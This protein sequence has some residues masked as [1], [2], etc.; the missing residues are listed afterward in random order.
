[1]A[2]S[3]ESVHEEKSVTERELKWGMKVFAQ[4][5]SVAIVKLVSCPPFCPTLLPS[6]PTAENSLLLTPAL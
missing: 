6:Y 2:Y 5:T 1:M 3:G 4:Y